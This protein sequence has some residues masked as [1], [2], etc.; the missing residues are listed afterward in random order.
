MLV[1][2]YPEP[3]FQVKRTETQELIFDPLRRKWLRLTPEEW[4]RQNF[5]QYLVQVKKYP[6]ALIA[7]EKIIRLGE[8][9]KRFDI[10]VY[11]LQHQPWMMIECKAPSVNLDE[12]V[13]HQLLRYHISVPTGF[14]VISNGNTSYGWEKKD[15]NLLLIHELPEWRDTGH[16]LHELNI[17]N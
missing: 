7:M 5:V 11:D 13:L 1:I 16:E 14:L 8:L 12:L 17:E 2:Q 9:R 4:V 6:A 10:L 15:R 3:I